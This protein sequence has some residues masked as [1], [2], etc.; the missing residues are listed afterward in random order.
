MTRTQEE[1]IEI[2]KAALDKFPKFKNVEANERMLLE[3]CQGRP[4]NAVPAVLRQIESK[5]AVNPDYED[6]YAQLWTRFPEY[7]SE[8]N[9][10]IL[11]A[12]VAVYQTI[13]YDILRKLVENPKVRE[14]LTLTTHA[15]NAIQDE[16]E[17]QRR[18]ESILGYHADP[19]T[20]E[21]TANDKY[22]WTRQDGKRIVGYRYELEKDDLATLIFTDDYVQEQR[23]L[24]AADSKEIREA[25]R[26]K[27]IREAQ[28]R[29]GLTK[30][31][32][33]YAPVPDYYENPARPGV[34]QQWS[35]NLLRRLPNSEIER[36]FNLYGEQ[37]LTIAC[38]K[39]LSQQ[40]Q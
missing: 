33:T 18:I 8:A 31:E 15:F 4:I 25:Q 10:S 23:R 30:A 27:E 24:Y 2:I 39:S 36:V 11:D 20:G 29:A 28:V 32:P 7:K 6:A 21:L 13:D 1:E 5:L 40:L 17:R 35:E 38:R 3:A 19:K 37:A 22:E 12:R 16:K 14:Q 26:K 34:R 9:V